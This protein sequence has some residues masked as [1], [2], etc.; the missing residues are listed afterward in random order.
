MPVSITTN[1]R[2]SACRIWIL[3]VFNQVFN[4]EDIPP[5]LIEESKEAL[6]PH[7]NGSQE[8]NN[9]NNNERETGE[10]KEHPPVE[11]WRASES[12]IGNVHLLY[13]LA[14]PPPSGRQLA[15]YRVTPLTGAAN[16]DSSQARHTLHNISMPDLQYTTYWYINMLQAN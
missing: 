5:K 1:N 10:H 15:I 12:W 13:T 16:R 2:G 4:H 14:A 8:S 11:C 3:F 6:L 7:L 9:N